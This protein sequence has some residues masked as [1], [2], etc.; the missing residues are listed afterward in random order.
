MNLLFAVNVLMKMLPAIMTL[1][2][3][4]FNTSQNNLNVVKKK[5]IGDE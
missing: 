2:S 4:Y 1:H 3:K 5:T